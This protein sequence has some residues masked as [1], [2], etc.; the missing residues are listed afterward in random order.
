LDAE[1]LGDVRILA[2]SG[3]TLDRIRAFEEEGVPIDAYGIGAALL[4]GRT[5]FTSTLIEMDAPLR[6]RVGSERRPN[7]R[8]ER[9]R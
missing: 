2:S 5:G 6:V 3:M 8:L 4:A 7:A 9:V 1:G